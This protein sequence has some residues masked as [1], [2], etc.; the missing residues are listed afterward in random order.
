MKA[1]QSPNTGN[2]VQM[3]L[4]DHIRQKLAPI[5]NWNN[6]K[7]D[8]RATWKKRIY[9]LWATVQQL[10]YCKF[11]KVYSANRKMDARNLV[12]DP[13]KSVFVSK[14]AFRRV[15]F[16]AKLEMHKN[17]FTWRRKQLL[18]KCGLLPYDS[19]VNCRV[20]IQKHMLLM[21]KG[22][23]RI[24]R[25]YPQFLNI[26]INLYQHRSPFFSE[27]STRHELQM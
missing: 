2:S 17:L 18:H 3:K 1:I 19:L 24:R 8:C 14:N 22:E 5:F 10:L 21:A 6:L 16:V 9:L 27:K 11:I 12:L 26:W 13:W 4:Q 25:A 23:Y 20:W 7:K 15:F